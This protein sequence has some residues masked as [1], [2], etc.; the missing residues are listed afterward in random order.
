MRSVSPFR[1][2]PAL[3]AGIGFRPELRGELFLHRSGVDFLEI[4]A[5]H[6]L[7]AP[8]EKMEELEL[9]EDHFTLIPHGLSLSLGTAEGI[10]VDYARRLAALV[11]RVDP[12]WWSEHLAFTRA[13]GVDIGHLAPLPLTREAIDVVARNVEA[14]RR[15]V[16]APLLLEN[17]T[18]SVT[19]PGAEMDE[20]EFLTET[21]ERTGCGWLLDVTNLFTNAVNHGTDWRRF[22]DRAPLERVV[23]L[24]FTGGHWHGGQLVD[25]HSAATPEA[26]W[27]VLEAVVE[28]APVKG[29]IL[30]RDE[31]MPPFADLLGEIA[32]AREV[33]R[34]RGR[35]A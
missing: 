16:D 11:A 33:G 9:L 29:M 31:R 4:T 7:E 30:E 19:L 6:Y 23:Q 28:R 34:R 12:P 32:R 25:S 14:V 5:D 20:A 2:L 24:H 22:L 1:S 27:E 26:V 21:L 8:P 35:W 3:G 17:I 18:Y 15:L 10:D 13:G